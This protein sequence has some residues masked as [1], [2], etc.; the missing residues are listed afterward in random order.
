MT[1]A[2]PN[3][4]WRGAHRDLAREHGFEP[5]RIEGRLPAAINGVLYK[6]GPSVFRSGDGPYLHAF[7][8]DGA[9]TAVRFAGGEA[10]GAVRVSETRWLRAERA[11]NRQ[12]YRS[13][14]QLGRG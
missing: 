4:A 1:S 10:E 9:S 8:G 14:A 5:L 3:P 12:L 6:N 11:A 2:E 13:Y 7:D